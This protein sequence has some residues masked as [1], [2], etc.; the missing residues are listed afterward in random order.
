[1]YGFHANPYVSIVTHL[2]LP[3]IF[4]LG[5]LLIPVGIWLKRRREARQGWPAPECGDREL[6]RTGEG[7]ERVG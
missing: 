5:L 1:M 2:I 4:L 7:C 6:D 3:G